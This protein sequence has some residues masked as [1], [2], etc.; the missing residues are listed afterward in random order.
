MLKTVINSH[1]FYNVPEFLKPK[2][3]QFIL[4]KKLS[5]LQIVWDILYLFVRLMLSAVT[6]WKL[7]ITMTSYFLICDLQQRFLRI[8]LFWLINI[9]WEKKL[10][11]TQFVTEQILLFREYLNISNVPAY[12]PET[13]WLYIRRQIYLKKK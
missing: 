7:F 9:C 12:I 13:L 8:I 2:D 3:V 11:L 6:Q 10:K 4:L 1:K 5:V